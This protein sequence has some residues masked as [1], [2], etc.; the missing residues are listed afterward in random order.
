LEAEA[1]R[2][3]EGVA[4][5]LVAK[6]SRIDKEGLC[7]IRTAA[8]APLLLQHKANHLKHQ[9]SPKERFSFLPEGAPQEMLC[10]RIIANRSSRNSAIQTEASISACPR[11]LHSE[12][13]IQPN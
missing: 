6:C 7:P 8:M 13:R 9:M 5:A 3:G 4:L 1:S 2:Q 10:V 11:D 12:E